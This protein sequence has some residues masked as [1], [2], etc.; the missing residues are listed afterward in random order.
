MRLRVLLLVLFVLSRPSIGSG[1]GHGVRDDDPRAPARG[2]WHAALELRA[3]TVPQ[4]LT[5]LLERARLDLAL[6]FF[7]QGGS[8]LE[9]LSAASERPDATV[10][11]LRAQ[12]AYAQ[13]RHLI[14]GLLFAAAAERAHGTTA[15]V[16]E[17]RAAE[18]FEQ[19]G[20][21]RLARSHYRRAARLLPQ[22]AGWLAIRE[23]RLLTDTA[24][25]ARL[26]ARTGPAERR[27]AAGVWADALARVGDTVGAVRI[28][29]LAG[30]PA[31]AAAMA[32]SANDRSVGRRLFYRALRDGG[33]ADLVDALERALPAIPPRNADEVVAVVGALRQVGRTP[34]AVRLLQDAVTAS[35]NPRVLIAAAEALADAGDRTAA[36]NTLEHVLAGPGHAAGDV[37]YA[38]AR[39]LLRVRGEHAGIPALLAFASRFRDHSAVP[40]ALFLAADARD[41]AGHRRSADSLY[42]VIAARWP[43]DPAGG[44]ALLRLAAAA[45]RS[46]RFDRAREL[47]ATVLAAGVGE[48]AAAR[49]RLG[50]ASL[51]AGD[52]AAATRE[53]T[54]LAAADSLGYY[55]LL[56]REALGLPPPAISEPVWPVAGS[57]LAATL[58]ALALLDA[59]E[60]KVEADALV[61]WALGEL[62]D[63]G[64]QLLALGHRLLVAGRVEAA[65]NIGWR[66]SAVV[67]MRDPRVLHL[68]FPW[69]L[70]D[71]VV[72]EARKFR[73]DP[74]LLAGLIRQESMFRPAVI[75]RAGAHG[76]MQLMPGTAAEVARRLGVEW[77]DGL[78]SV[79]DANL[80]VG[81]AHLASLLRRFQGNEVLA[82][83]AYNAGGRPVERWRQQWRASPDWVLFVEQIPYPETR[84]YVRTVVRNR[85][86]Y[87]ALYPPTDSQ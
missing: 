11:R 42:Q 55:A 6:G 53:W 74:Y 27:V 5:A 87:R 57:L 70:R 1:L 9:K 31:A 16:L 80:H 29:A 44:Q 76:L 32:L 75:S 33:T 62:R 19:A 69:P 30:R 21:Q 85:T 34:E 49:F 64:E 67:G 22:T 63:D 12:A 23:A 28:K 56:A 82:L 54:A 3:G 8:L 83:A 17:G 61:E 48:A 4:D 86:L 51:R 10:L 47:Y 26:L 14:A 66:A 13:G 2:I 72:A 7:G 58:P 39:L 71:L 60:F 52:S 84:G 50:R 68:I 78:L 15:G 79:A 46:R 24:A 59:M 35:D 73:I 37:A 20:V 36:L 18:A 81:A 45:E 40:A 38:R 41:R 43:R 25:I 65:V 77:H